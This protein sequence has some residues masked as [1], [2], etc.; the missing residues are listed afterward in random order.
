MTSQRLPLFRGATCGRIR[1]HADR[2]RSTLDLVARTPCMRPASHG[3]AL[4]R[5]G[6]LILEIK[7]RKLSGVDGTP[8]CLDA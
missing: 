1:H 4:S 8:A 7:R 5:G 6:K 3:A 2:V